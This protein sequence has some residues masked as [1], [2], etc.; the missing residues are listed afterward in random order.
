MIIND[1]DNHQRY[2]NV[3]YDKAY[4][5]SHKEQMRNYQK[6]YYLSHKDQNQIF[7]KMER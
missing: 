3:V 2:R 4:A 5:A 1:K 6:T 7:R